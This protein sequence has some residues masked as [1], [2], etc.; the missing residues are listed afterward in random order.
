MSIPAHLQ[1]LLP[2]QMATRAVITETARAF[3]MGSKIHPNRAA[4]EFYPTPP[5]ATLALLSAE[6][7]DGSIWE[8]A[9]GEGHIA[10]VLASAGY[11]VTSTDLVVYGFGEP[12]RDF[13][14]ER[15]PLAK[16]IVTNPPYG[17]GLADAFAKHAIRLTRETGG[18]VAMLMNLAGL[19][20]PLRHGFYVSHP[21]AVVYCLDECICWPYGDPSQATTSIAKQRYCWMVWK[22]G[23]TGATELRWLSTREHRQ[24]Y[25]G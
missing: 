2:S 21:P 20:H 4:Y 23:H 8:P 14:A 7:F 16:H 22:H 3:R 9:C 24:P 11:Q 6:A 17:R 18:T 13:L 12:K 25:C 5:E 1:L 19:C 15:K 10:K